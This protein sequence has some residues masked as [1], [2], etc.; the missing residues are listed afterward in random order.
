MNINHG[1]A[2]IEFLEHR[3]VQG[4]AE[5][6]VAVIGLQPDAIR[7]ERIEG[8]LD[9]AQAAGSELVVAIEIAVDQATEGMLRAFN[10]YVLLAGGIAADAPARRS[11]RAAGLVVRIALRYFIGSAP[12][13]GAAIVSRW[14]IESCWRHIGID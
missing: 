11:R 4:I 7:L 9:L 8:V 14:R 13:L 6:F 2:A 5:P 1:L 3:R 12:R 10:L